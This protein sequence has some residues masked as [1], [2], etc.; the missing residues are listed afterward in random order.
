MMHWAVVRESWRKGLAVVVAVGLSSLVLRGLATQSAY[1]DGASDEAVQAVQLMAM[2]GVMPLLAVA[3]A[4]ARAL[5][6]DVAW[7]LARPLPRWPL[8]AIRVAT[9]TSIL[10]AC[11]LVSLA[12]LGV[13]DRVAAVEASGSPVDVTSPWVVLLVAILIHGCTAAF[14]TMGARPLAAAALGLAW[15]ASMVAVP[16]VVRAAG[17]EWLSYRYVHV[18]SDPEYVVLVVASLG[19]GLIALLSCLGIAWRMVLAG[20]R[21][22]PLAAPVGPLV[23]QSLYVQALCVV[24]HVAAFAYADASIDRVFR[25]GEAGIRASF[26][27]VQG[28]PIMAWR[29]R[30]VMGPDT[31]VP[32]T[33]RRY[34]D[35]VESARGQRKVPPIWGVRTEGEVVDIA[36]G[37]YFL[38]TQAIPEEAL[39]DTQ[40]LACWE[41]ADT[42]DE[43]AL[44]EVVEG[45]STVV[46]TLQTPP[47]WQPDCPWLRA[48]QPSPAA[49]R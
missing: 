7:V 39:A 4:G 42:R 45:H 23:R 29:P 33:P 48:E 28:R 8:A 13:P 32:S 14:V 10:A 21:H 3:L 19:T 37:T 1:G 47:P 27:D 43:C 11:L 9:D 15:V 22:A 35:S 38:C 17:L 26:Q 12:V 30:L 41:Q 2:L 46:V 20:A 6:A 36:P 5:D 16:I 34:L 40:R 44:V 25:R 24:I 31:P 18:R 49:S